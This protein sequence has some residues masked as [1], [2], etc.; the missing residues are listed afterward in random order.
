MDSLCRLKLSLGIPIS[1]PWRSSIHQPPV[2]QE[3]NRWPAR[4]FHAQVLAIT[5]LFHLFQIIDF[6]PTTK[7]DFEF[8][9]PLSSENFVIGILPPASG[10]TEQPT[11][12]QVLTNWPDCGQTLA[13]AGQHRTDAGQRRP[14]PGQRLPK[15]VNHRAKS[16]VSFSRRDCLKLLR[17]MTINRV[18]RSGC[19]GLILDIP[20]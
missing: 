20:A 5:E 3:Q 17:N 19:V 9:F 10:Q 7:S 15:L 14:P 2:E 1:R 6:K 13:K 12:L 11:I 4:L 16:S 18:G 8:G